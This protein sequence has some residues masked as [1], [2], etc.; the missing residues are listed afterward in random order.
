MNKKIVALAVAAAFAVPV[1]ASAQTTLFGQFKYEVGYIDS[2]NEALGLDDSSFVHSTKGTRLGVRGSEDL[3]SGL[4]GIYRFQ[5]GLGQVNSGMSGTSW[6]M[7]EEN[8]VG[9][10]GG[11]GTLQLGRSDT[12]MKKTGGNQFRAFTDTLAEPSLI[13]DRTAR[14]E[15]I[16]Y[17]T[18]NIAG[19]NGYLTLEPNGFETDTYWAVGADYKLGAFYLAAAYE[20]SPDSIPDV[21]GTYAAGIGPDQSNWQVGGKWNFG[22][23]DV[24]LLYQ[25][26]TDGDRE[27]FLVPVNF[28]VTPNVNLR[29]AVKYIDDDTADGGAGADWTNWG[30]GAQYMFSARTEAFVNVWIDDR[31]GQTLTAGNNLQDLVEDVDGSISQDSTQFGF[32]VRHSF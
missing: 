20:S 7:N 11:F 9:L 4:K 23:G 30:I 17:T 18:P 25:S 21:Y 1:A 32:G 19:F 27:V 5:S 24:G 2:Q 22:Q 8:W 6:S 3:G 15:G 10:Q 16:H 31:A 26:V 14:A 29:A 12:A 13:T 28:K